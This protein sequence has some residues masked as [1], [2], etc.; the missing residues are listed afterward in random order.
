MRLGRY[1]RGLTEQD[2]L[3]VTTLTAKELSGAIGAA[4]KHYP[5][6]ADVLHVLAWTGL[7]LGEAC[8]LQWG[9]LD[10]AGGFLEV[11][12]AIT[13]RQHKVL[14]GAR[15]SGQARRVD[16]PGVLVAPVRR[17]AEHPSGRGCPRRS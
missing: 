8:G 15:K 14:I 17:A 7:R 6:H 10:A 3:K 9:D 1:S 2:A 16:A 12:R 5:E 11:R 4:L 13:Y